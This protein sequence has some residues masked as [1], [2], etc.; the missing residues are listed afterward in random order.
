MADPILEKVKNLLNERKLVD[1]SIQPITFLEILYYCANND[2]LSDFTRDFVKKVIEKELECYDLNKDYLY[3][4]NEREKRYDVVFFNCRKLLIEEL[5]NKPLFTPLVSAY[6][7]PTARLSFV[8]YLDKMSKNDAV[9]FI[10]H[11]KR[12]IQEE[13][14]RNFIEEKIG[15]NLLPT[16]IEEYKIFNIIKYITNEYNHYEFL[17][18]K[19]FN[20]FDTAFK[21]NID[22]SNV[23][24]LVKLE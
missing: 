8:K 7:M 3:E 19:I 10:H 22:E 2:D 9:C 14:I 6:K 11:E 16:E 1:F 13:I 20:N 17:K 12:V 24:G 21:F 15:E 23:F 18:N 4:K 5:I